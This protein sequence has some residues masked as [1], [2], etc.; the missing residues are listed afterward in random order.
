V[1][2]LDVVRDVGRSRAAVVVPEEA[3]GLLERREAA[4]AAKD[5]AT[6][7]ALREQLAVLGIA[8]TDT[9]DGQTWSLV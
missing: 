1:L 9:S 2:G 4:R 8:V 6:S 7:D 3:Q 5:W